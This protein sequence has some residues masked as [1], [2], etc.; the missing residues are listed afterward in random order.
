MHQEDNNLDYYIEMCEK[1]NMDESTLQI[2]AALI[3]KDVKYRRNYLTYGQTCWGTQR[4]L[5]EICFFKNSNII[6]YS[7]FTLS[8]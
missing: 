4:T 1:D 2:S 6:Q 3:A 8:P 7:L 5:I